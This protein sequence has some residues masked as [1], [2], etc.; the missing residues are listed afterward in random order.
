MVKKFDTWVAASM[1]QKCGAK[2]TI[3]VICWKPLFHITNMISFHPDNNS[4]L[5]IIIIFPG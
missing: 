4:D 2:I 1:I 5:G 3:I